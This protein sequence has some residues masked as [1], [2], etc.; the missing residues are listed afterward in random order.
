MTTTMID[1]I[2]KYSYVTYII[3]AIIWLTISIINTEIYNYY[4][5]PEVEALGT[6]MPDS[7]GIILIFF[8]FRWRVEKDDIKKVAILKKTLNILSIIFVAITILSATIFAYKFN[9]LTN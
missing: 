5:S 7:E 4:K 1:I 2:I 8:T 6:Y 9:H 3:W